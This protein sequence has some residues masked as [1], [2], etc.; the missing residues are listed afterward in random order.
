[1]CYMCVCVL[2]ANC[3]YVT[4]CVCVYSM[5]MQSIE[6]VFTLYEQV[7][8]LAYLHGL[9]WYG[10][11]VCIA[12]LSVVFRE[13][14]SVCFQDNSRGL[15]ERLCWFKGITNL[16]RQNQLIICFTGTTR[17]TATPLTVPTN[18]THQWWLAKHHY[19]MLT[20][21][22]KLREWKER[23]RKRQWEE[24]KT[25]RKRE[26]YEVKRQSERGGQQWKSGGETQGER[27]WCC[28]VIFD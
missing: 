19:K 23:G 17:L 13:Y 20:L 16:L 3:K 25:I 26:G 11:W 27:R 24:K 7:C 18:T 10:V 4:F 6:H 8:S 5:S 22:W 28:R 15:M 1:M 12:V 9:R 21:L 14:Y 2:E